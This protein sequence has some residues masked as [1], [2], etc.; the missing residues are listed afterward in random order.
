MQVLLD[1]AAVGF[2][3]RT[4]SQQLLLQHPGVPRQQLT[5]LHRPGSNRLVHA[6][7]ARPAGAT[8]AG[9]TLEVVVH[10]MGRN[11]AGTVFDL[12]G[13]ASQSVTLAGARPTVPVGHTRAR[14]A[15]L[16]A[17]LSRRAAVCPA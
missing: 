1:A 14:P 13:L 3:D 7:R 2:L 9:S 8:L 12:K 10:G 5:G 6:G 4:G 11:S 15:L 16:D 17:V